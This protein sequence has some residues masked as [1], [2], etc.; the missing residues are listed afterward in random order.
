MCSRFLVLLYIIEKT[1]DCDTDMQECSAELS[2]TQ[3]GSAMQLPELS[4][5]QTRSD[6][7]LP[8]GG[9]KLTNAAAL[10]DIPDVNISENKGPLRTFPGIGF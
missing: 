2:N 1:P 5:T 7:Q 10:T 9:V 6:I 8:A 3:T 4:N